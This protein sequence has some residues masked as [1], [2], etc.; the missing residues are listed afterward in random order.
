M[1]SPGKLAAVRFASPLTEKSV[2]AVARHL[3]RSLVFPLIA[4]LAVACSPTARSRPPSTSHIRLEFDYSAAERMVEAIDRPSLS[5]AEASGRK[6][7][8][9]VMGFSIEFAEETQQA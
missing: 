2:M 1:Q 4:L 6:R 8:K 9:R 3:S 5:E 7:D